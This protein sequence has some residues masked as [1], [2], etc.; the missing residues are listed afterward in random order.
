MKKGIVLK[1]NHSNVIVLTPDGDFLKCKKIVSSYAIG[2][3]I[4]F[5]NHAVIVNKKIKTYIPKLLPVMIAS[6]L[7]FMSVLLFDWNKEK[8]VAAGVVNIDSDA[9]VSVIIDKHLKVIGLKSKNEQGKKVID[10]MDNWK[11]Q[12]LNSVMDE[13]IVEM[14]K[15]NV[16]QPDEKVILSGEMELEHKNQQMNLI[17]E[18]NAIKQR[19]S[20]I[21]I[22]QPNVK[23]RKD[24]KEKQNQSNSL[25]TDSTNQ[26]NI[27]S[28]HNDG[29]KESNTVLNNGNKNNNDKLTNHKN[30]DDKY[31]SWHNNKSECKDDNCEKPKTDNNQKNDYSRKH[32]LE[33]KNESKE[34][35]KPNSKKKHDFR[36]SD[37]QK[38]NSDEEDR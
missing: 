30:T 27:K 2:E 19:N 18:L 29:K 24:K 10:K 5:P 22:V 32:W 7:I 11:Q 26:H 25:N 15:S 14:E 13:L 28:K 38:H 34:K 31:N 6:A 3:E 12:S 9:K 16:I 36:V 23:K 4:Q 35:V 8:V 1:I 37:N 20:H 33:N 21:N 17:N